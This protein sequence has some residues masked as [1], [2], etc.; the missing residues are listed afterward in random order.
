MT[1][2]AAASTTFDFSAGACMFVT[3]GDTGPHLHRPVVSL[4]TTKARSP[5]VS[6]NTPPPGANPGGRMTVVAAPEEVFAAEPNGGVDRM[7]P[8]RLTL[9]DFN[10]D[11]RLICVQ[12]LLL[13]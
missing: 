4:S 8:H 11:A 9:N 7:R 10:A 6:T 5:V 13:T 1:V 2:A 12:R 3:I